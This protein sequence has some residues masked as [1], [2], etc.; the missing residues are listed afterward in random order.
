VS[1]AES[2]PAPLS[3]DALLRRVA[4]ALAHGLVLFWLYRAAQLD[5][6]PATHQGL[7]AALATCALLLPVT[8]YLIDGL[9]RRRQRLALLAATAAA[10]LLFGW[11]LGARASVAPSGSDPRGELVVGSAGFLAALGVLWY[12]ALPFAQSWLRSG[13]RR[14]AYPDLFEFAWRNGLLLALGALFCGVTW[15][16][17]W[18]WAQLF[19]LLGIDFFGQLFANSAFAIPATAIAAGVGVQLAGNVE[20]LQRALR[21]NLLSLLKWLAPLSALIL[22]LFSSALLFKLPV[23]LGTQR[24]VVGAAWLL[25]LVAVNV[26]LLNAAWQDGRHAAPYPR[27]LA[28]ALRLALPLLTLIAAIALYAVAVRIA[29]HGLTVQRTWAL[30]VALLAVAYS[31]GYAVAAMLRSLPPTW[32]ARIGTVNVGIA[33]AT[34]V[35]LSLMLTPLLAPERLAAASQQARILADP[36]RAVEEDYRVLRFETGEYGRRALAA[37]AGLEDHPQAEQIR[38]AATAMRERQQRWPPGRMSTDPAALSLD[39]FPVGT[40][41]DD[42]LRAAIA[43]VAFRGP[44]P[45]AR[46][47]PVLFVDLDGDGAVEAVAFVAPYEVPLLRRTDAGWEQAGVIRPADGVP[48]EAEALRS[49]LQQQRVTAQEPAWQELAID[50]SKLYLVA[51]T[52]GSGPPT[53]GQRDDRQ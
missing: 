27:P 3:R 39:A 15:L 9:G 11:H 24:R 49:A 16:L 44:C 8:G 34:I 30:L 42:A 12:H 40:P 4:L 25:W 35:T 36:G 51:P 20:S 41:I 48:L 38:S 33:V 43:G 19:R 21:Q 6:W 47:C 32:L 14:P 13:H 17:L 10:L 46:P 22:V 28:K 53:P 5:F 37:L 50:G 2:G 7:I 52:P 1:D 18:L 45:S 26:L 31:V 23:L 29:D